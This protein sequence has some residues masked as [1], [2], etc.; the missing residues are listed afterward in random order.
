MLNLSRDESGTEDT[1][2]ADHLS[3]GNYSLGKR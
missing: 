2:I 1:S 3:V